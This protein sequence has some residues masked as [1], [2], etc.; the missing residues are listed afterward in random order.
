[1]ASARALSPERKLTMT[2][3]GSLPSKANSHRLIR[4]FILAFRIYVTVREVYDSGGGVALTHRLWEYLR[5]LRRVGF[6]GALLA[7]AAILTAQTA[8]PAAWQD[9][10]TPIGPSDWNYDLAAHLLERAGFGGTPA[11]IDALAKMTPAKA[12]ARL[13][14]FGEPNA[15]KL[16]ASD[17]PE[18]TTPDSDPSPP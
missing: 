16:P 18:F 17:I 3:S 15:G 14:R 6:F 12:V 7:A 2:A 11:E 8:G 10:L 1:M 4:S 9:D 13:V 5:M